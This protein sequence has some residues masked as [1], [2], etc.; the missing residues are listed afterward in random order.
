MIVFEDGNGDFFIPEKV[1]AS[2]CYGGKSGNVSIMGSTPGE[3][4]KVLGHW[5]AHP[6]SGW[7]RICAFQNGG[8]HSDW[9]G[10]F[11]R[12]RGRRGKLMQ[13][14]WS[15]YLNGRSRASTFKTFYDLVRKMAEVG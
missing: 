6:G 13:R 12:D 2:R 15:A 9:H 8:K 5:K 10:V 14:K 11:F 7:V 3:I 4:T 1:I